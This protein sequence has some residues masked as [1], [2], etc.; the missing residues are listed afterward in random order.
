MGI[1]RT[2]LAINDAIKTIET[3]DALITDPKTEGRKEGYSDAAS[4]YKTVYANQ[5]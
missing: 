1:L 4:E 3:V 5:E 2:L